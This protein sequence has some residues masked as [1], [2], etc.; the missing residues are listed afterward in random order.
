MHLDWRPLVK[1][2]REIGALAL[3]LGIWAGIS[4]LVVVFAW[5]PTSAWWYFVLPLYL[6]APL[7]AFL[8]VMAVRPPTRDNCI[9]RGVFLVSLGW[10]LGSPIPIYPLFAHYTRV[11]VF[12]RVV[13]TSGEDPLLGMFVYSLLSFILIGVAYCGYSAYWAGRLASRVLHRQPPNGGSIE[14]RAILRH[15]R[16][17]VGNGL[18]QHSK[19]VQ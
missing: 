16:R 9:K 14:T 12:F 8:Y 2:L 3:A 10:I 15:H 13:P 1:T 6:P 17:D 5:Q 7:A 19:F 4:L 11:F 18:Q